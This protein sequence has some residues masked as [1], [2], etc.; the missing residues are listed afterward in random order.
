MSRVYTSKDKTRF[1]PWAVKPVHK[2]CYERE[3]PW[4]FYM[5]YWNGRFWQYDGCGGGSCA[6]QNRLWRGLKSN[7]NAVGAPCAG[8]LPDN[9][10]EKIK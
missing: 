10:T 8:F 6:N 3:Y 9:L 2:G 5:D 1:F 7:P 4:G